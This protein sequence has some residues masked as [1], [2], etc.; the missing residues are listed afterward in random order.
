MLGAI[1]HTCVHL[2]T[3]V[4]FLRTLVTPMLPKPGDGP[5][6]AFRADNHWKFCLHGWT[7]EEGKSRGK[8][9]QVCRRPLITWTGISDGSALDSTC[10]LMIW[11]LVPIMN[12]H[13]TCHLNSRVV[14][15]L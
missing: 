1:G 12:H 2:F 14:A 4:P 13:W 11:K 6:A 9:C 8:L 15:A 5:P 10:S 7:V 3:T